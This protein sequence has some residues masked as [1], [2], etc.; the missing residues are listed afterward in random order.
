MNAAPDHHTLHAWLDGELSPERMAEVEAWLHAH[1]DEEARVRLWAADADAIRAQ[2]KDVLDEPVPER[3]LQTVMRRG[4]VPGRAAA[5]SEDTAAGF[6]EAMT[7][8]A[9][10]AAATAA[11]RPAA[12]AFAS[13]PA[14]PS[15]RVP[16]SSTGWRW[17]AALA[18]FALGGAVGAALM[19][20]LQPAPSAA[21]ARAATDAQA[22]GA[23]TQRAVIAHSVYVP[24]VRHPVEVDVVGKTPE[25]SRAQEQHLSRWL[26]KRLDVPV[27]LFDLHAQG[28]E[29]VGGRLLPDASGPSAQLMYQAITPV[30]ADGVVAAS[31]GPAA[32]PKPARVTVYLRKPDSSMPA[33][34]RF[35]QQGDLGMFYWVEGQSPHG[36]PTGYALVG[37]L[38]RAKLLT[39]AEAIYQQG[40]AP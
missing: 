15:A 28:F 8:A 11:T 7:S 33:A 2:L 14:R 13:T 29:L 20:R 10:A 40:A 35:E 5:S 16:S 27:K 3:L 25:E 4:A 1:P 9:A 37:A 12:S 26:T 32:A 18:V 34:F 23:W 30:A 38:P 31:A 17:A 22:P 6:G 39:L 19:W 21:L 24:E 36:G